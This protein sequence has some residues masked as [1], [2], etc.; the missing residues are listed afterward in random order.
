MI[1]RRVCDTNVPVPPT[2]Q[3]TLVRAIGRWSLAAL[4][5]NSIVGSAVFG[6]P[7][8]VAGLVGRASLIAVPVAGVATAVIV[9]CYAEL[10]SQFTQSGGTYLYVRAAFGR[11]AGIQVGWFRLLT[12][13]T[14]TAAAANL[15]VIYLGALWRPATFA[16]PRLLILTLLVGVLAAV[17]Y[18]GVRAGTQVSNVFVAAK[19]L[20]LGLVCVTGAFHLIAMHRVVPPPTAPARA[21]AWLKA[22][23]VLFF[24]Y[25]GSEAALV[26]M[27]EA[28]DPR[29]DAP[30][31]VFV[32]LITV[33]VIYILI[34]WVVIGVLPDPA[35]S[36]RPLSDAMN[37]LTGRC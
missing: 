30:F 14:S 8:V 17:N 25:A 9:A 2:Q 26:P 24:A 5:V 27:G 7:S 37:I 29:R 18:R 10:S 16:T 36:D 28:K 22:M 23:L 33:G 12:Q 31:A 1:C 11:F 15:F 4:V 21:G 32:A 6:L 3:P 20:P 34:Q 13:L 19:L 35:H